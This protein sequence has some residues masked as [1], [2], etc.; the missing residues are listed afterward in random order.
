[1]DGLLTQTLRLNFLKLVLILP[2]VSI[3]KLEC[4]SGYLHHE[5]LSSGRQTNTA[6]PRVRL[7][8]DVKNHKQSSTNF[9]VIHISYISVIVQ[10]HRCSVST[11][12]T[13]SAGVAHTHSAPTP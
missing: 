1:M 3:P 12:T 13:A 11:T 10:L 9:H 7:R 6:V 8:A 2:S 5:D 4:Q